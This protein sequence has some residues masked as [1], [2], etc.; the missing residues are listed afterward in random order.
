MYTTKPRRPDRPRTGPGPC[1]GLGPGVGVAPECSGVLEAN[2]DPGPEALRGRRVP[3]SPPEIL[4]RGGSGVRWAPAPPNPNSPQYIPIWGW[5]WGGWFGLFVRNL[6]FYLPMRV[7]SLH[8]KQCVY[9]F[10]EMN[11]LTWFCNSCKI[12]YK[13]T[14]YFLL[15]SLINFQFHC[16]V[17]YSF[18]LNIA[19]FSYVCVKLRGSSDVCEIRRVFSCV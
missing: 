19:L 1:T 7:V 3:E 10:Y 8:H 17:R 16:L 6:C 13:K 9:Q 11:R 5:G 4:R 2:L 15:C 14:T 12:L 18:F